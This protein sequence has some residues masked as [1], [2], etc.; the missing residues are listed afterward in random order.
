MASLIVTGG[1]I[2]TM[3]RRKRIF[4]KGSVVI[5]G[6]RIADVGKFREIRSRHRAEETINANGCLVMP[7]LINC[8]IHLPQ[9]LMRGV[10]DDVEVMEK[11]INYIWP[12]QGHYDEKDGRISSLLAFLEMIKSGTTSFI[13]TGLHPRYGIDGI[14]REL[15]S[16][17]L[18]GAVSKYIME[19][20]AYATEKMA[21][22]EGLHE[23]KEGSMR[24]ALRLI[25]EWNGKANDRIRIW[26]SPRSVGAC[27]AE[28][29][30]EISEIA[31]KYGV[32][33]TTHWAE[34]E[35]NVQYV[36]KEFH[37][38]MAEFAKHVGFL[39]PNVTMA[40]GIWFENG[41]IGSL[42]RSGV[43]ICHCPVTNSKLAMH[44]AKIP[45]ML[46]AGINVCLGTDGAP[47]NNTCD[48]FQE[49]RFAVL[50]HRINS[51]DPL[52]PRAEEA[53][54]MATINGAKAM[55]LQ[56]ELGSI[57]IG[58][59]ADII[60]VD[61]KNYH[62]VPI[63]SPTSAA[64]WATTGSDVKT[65]IV[66]GKLIMENRRV[67]T[68]N[69]EKILEEAQERARKVLQKANIEIKEKWPIV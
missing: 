69:E 64:V 4:K 22:H 17:G 46:R 41:E 11:L 34:A 40:H 50:L 45:Q 1:I 48:M 8:H 21:I 68:L 15:E 13:S 59:K 26:L 65:V 10:Q 44:V 2:L 60:I 19:K 61:L 51:L 53:L 9:M 67:L 58:K 52:Y 23:T 37:M 29:L 16:S 63:H 57:E 38:G 20:G 39:A 7:G 12:I 14:L 31:R 35:N 25:K 27:S 62:A 56:N 47:V 54:E 30:K 24:E 49:M 5:E 43:N 32:G 18:R 3:D 28:T 33:I 42:A 55:G 66:D 36:R 6:G